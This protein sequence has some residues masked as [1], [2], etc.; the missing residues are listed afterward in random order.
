MDN[1]KKE[2]KEE[3]GINEQHSFRGNQLFLRGQS[4][5]CTFI[6]GSINVKE[7]QLDAC[8][9]LKTQ[10]F[11]VESFQALIFMRCQGDEGRF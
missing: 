2:G 3:E 1:A 6:L 10:K 7:I 5:N 9:R 11:H 4:N 8:T